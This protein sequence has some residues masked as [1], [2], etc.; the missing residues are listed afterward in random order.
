M[1][2]LERVRLWSQW[3]I[4]RGYYF[5]G[6]MHRYVG[7][8]HAVKVEYEK[9][10][11]DFTQAIHWDPNY[12][13]VYLDRGILYWRE[14]D[15]PRR[16]IQDLTIALTL[17]PTLNEAY[18]NRGIAYQ[19]LREYDRAVAEFKTYLE[20]GQHPYWREF[21]QNMIKELSEWLPEADDGNGEEND[22]NS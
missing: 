18:F 3:W 7:N 16:A 14:M 20:V 2:L 21:A 15:H 19:Q 5:S 4:S 9:A 13:Q 10:I 11:D 12:A 6:A 17:S 8:T 1:K 22:R